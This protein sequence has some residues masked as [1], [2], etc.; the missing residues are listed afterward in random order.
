M[1][2]EKSDQAAEPSRAEAQ[3]KELEEDL[4][5]AFCKRLEAAAALRDYAISKNL[6]ITDAMIDKIDGL[7]G[8]GGLPKN[9]TDLD[10]VIR[11]LTAITYPATADTVLKETVA[12]G[13]N[14]VWWLMAAQ[15]LALGSIVLLNCWP[16]ADATA[17]GAQSAVTGGAAARGSQTATAGRSPAAGSQAPPGARGSQ[18]GSQVQAPPG[19][20]DNINAINAIILGFLGASSFIFFNVLGHLSDKAF[21]PGDVQLNI[22][23]LLLGPA[24][25]WVF[26][27]AKLGPASDYKYL[28]QFLAGFSTRMVMGLLSQAISAVELT[29]GLENKATDLLARRRKAR[30]RSLES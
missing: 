10:K 18:P 20:D 3:C 17:T 19:R 4:D 13:R 29:L 24:L 6:P 1:P 25:G 8:S 22:I 14:F 21:S 16:V 5:R 28:I 11:D 12:A 2:P 7:L 30:S 9:A 15:V 26:F 23:R 27:K